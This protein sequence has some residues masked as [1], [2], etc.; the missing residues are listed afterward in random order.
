MADNPKP[1]QKSGWPW[2]RIILVLSLG[3]NLLVVGAVLGARLSDRGPGHGSEQIG[4][5][6]PIGA[7]GRALG[8]NDQRELGR[9]FR[10]EIR[11]RTVP[12]G[13]RLRQIPARVVGALIAEPYD[14]AKLEA[15]F[16]LQRDRMIELHDVGRSLLLDR[17]AAMSPEERARYAQ[18]LKDGLSRDGKPRP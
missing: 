6:M 3:F 15:L 5:T 14:P 7:Y 11:S 13:D 9:A 1:K 4:R 8:R 10:Q 2:M 16:E 17:I 12:D 18:R